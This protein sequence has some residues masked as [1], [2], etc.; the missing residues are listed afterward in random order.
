MRHRKVDQGRRAFVFSALLAMTPFGAAAN[1]ASGNFN[2]FP[3][4]ISHNFGKTIIGAPPQRIVTLGWG[5]EDA[6]IALGTI[7]VGMP[8]YEQF[9]NGIL[10]WVDEK[11]GATKPMLLSQSEIDFEAIALLK[12]DAI[13]AVRT[14]IDGKDWRR[15]NAIAPTIA[16]RSGPLQANWQEITLL[17]GECVGKPELARALVEQT[18]SRLHALYADH[19]VLMNRSFV[20]GSYFQGRSA[21]GVYFP[22]DLR[23]ATLME[24]GLQ[25]PSEVVKL[26]A[27]H[28][29][30]IG[31][32]VSFEQLDS[33]ETD[34]LIV[35]FPPGA[36]E[37]AEGQP[38]F[39]SY[40]P[41]VGGGFVALDDPVSIWV[42][43]NPSVLSIPYGYPD[44]VSRLA[45]AASKV[46]TKESMP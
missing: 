20:F 19:S 2:A 17:A 22:D 32:S 45:A 15:L 42:T 38:L 44:F 4:T 35:W 31:T 11:L 40:A 16:Y 27:E 46:S 24:L 6:L 5:G 7:P 9:A 36:K 3:V 12:P 30:Q 14:N 18:K 8:R 1:A 13:L 28:P 21:L 41:V 37:D 33:I 29:G 23:V 43:S 25:V 10:P 26:A 34:L 39:R